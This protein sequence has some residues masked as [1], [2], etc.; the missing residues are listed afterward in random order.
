MCFKH[1]CVCM[2]FLI[3]SIMCYFFDQILIFF[4]FITNKKSVNFL[5]DRKC[6]VL[7][8]LCGQPCMV[9]PILFHN[10]V[11]DYSLKNMPFFAKLCQVFLIDF[12][13]LFILKKFN[14][15]FCQILIYAFYF[16]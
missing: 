7:L 16:C 5:A 15:I 13:N 4:L 3:Y 2:H 6:A 11:F 9:V 1:F 8:N 12:E 14:Y 10:I